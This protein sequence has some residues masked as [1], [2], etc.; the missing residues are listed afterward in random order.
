[1]KK[2][3]IV[4]A[5]GFGGL[6]LIEIL[7]R[8]EQ[9]EIAQIV[10]RKDVGKRMSDVFPHLRGFCDLLVESPED[11]NL[12]NIDLAFFSTPDRAGMTMIEEFHARNIPVIDFSGD[13]RFNTV[14]DYTIYAANKGMETKH[15]SPSILTGA[16]YGLPEKYADKIKNAK[17]VGNPG[18]YAIAMILGLLPLVE[19][20]LIASDT[21]ICD[22]KTGV[23]GAGKNPGEANFYPQRH[24]DVNTYREGHHQ[25]TVEVENIIQRVGNNSKK[26]F[27][28]PQVVP[29]NRGILMNLYAQPTEPVNTEDLQTVYEKYY[30]DKPFVFVTASS[31]HTAHVRGSNMCVI[32]P[33]V[34]HRSGMLLVT[35]VIDNLLKGQSGN[36]IQCANIMM[37]FNETDGLMY[38]PFYP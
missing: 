25:H 29:L 30:G 7:L 22:G 1:M 31:P 11:M 14:D 35:S 26:I 27:F 17:I 28:I 4:G 18:C 38:P 12:D 2:V 13:F 21:I 34:D 20:G 10:A 33:M 32:R 3:L 37:G 9:F 6:G 23:S 16:V 5:T 8:H 24:E 36:A 19:N 15:H